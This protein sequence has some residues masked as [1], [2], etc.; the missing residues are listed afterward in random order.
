MSLNEK[1][2]LQEVEINEQS[3][4]IDELRNEIQLL[5]DR[6]EQRQSK[7]TAP[8]KSKSTDDHQ[9]VVEELEKK[10][11]ELETERTCLI[12]EHE[13]L[14]TNLDLC[15]DEKQHLLQQRTQNATELKKLKLRILALQDQIHKLK[16]TNPLTTTTTTTK[17]KSFPAPGSTMKKRGI[18]RKSKKSCLEM[19]LDQN[20]TLIDDLQD[21]S[22]LL[23][24]VS[25]TKSDRWRRPGQ[26][27]RACSLCD[28]HTQ[29]S[30]MKRK[31]RSSIPTKRINQTLK[32]NLTGKSRL[33]NSF[34]HDSYSH[35]AR[36]P[37][38][39]QKGPTRVGE[40]EFVNVMR[41]SACSLDWND[42]STY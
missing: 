4:V 31:R 3:I 38:G 29:S 22:S 12:F 26:R 9:R 14:K 7:F 42:A 17:K 2:D 10:V 13:R 1:I 18:K 32:K 16:R 23:Y 19:L 40:D 39:T 6:D 24:R 15:I 25:A 5:N 33:G 20:S 11:Y 30:L 34:L 8:T 37:L 41:N 28:N 35:Y 36:K 21:E 27:H